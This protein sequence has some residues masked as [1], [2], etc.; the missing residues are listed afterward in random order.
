M[1]LGTAA[2]WALASGADEAP[3]RLRALVAGASVMLPRAVAGLA[4]SGL[5]LLL[6][7]PVTV[8]VKASTGAP[9]TRTILTPFSGPPHLRLTWITWFLKSTDICRRSSGAD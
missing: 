2:Y 9:R 6:W 1:V 4:A 8:L 7:R 5:M 3:P